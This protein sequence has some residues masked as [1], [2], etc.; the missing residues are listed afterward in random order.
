MLGRLSPLSFFICE[1]GSMLPTSGHW[2]HEDGK[3]RGQS[4]RKGSAWNPGDLSVQEAG[5]GLGPKVRGAPGR[6]HREEAGGR[7]WARSPPHPSPLTSSPLPH[8][9][10][11]GA[12]SPLLL[13]PHPGRPSLARPQARSKPCPPGRPPQQLAG[14]GRV[15]WGFHSH[16][17]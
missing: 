15:S 14:R 1:M 8:T 17:G 10:A 5:C 2:G 7:V 12:C 11:M 6:A 3:Q 9:L 16:W 13:V 4:F